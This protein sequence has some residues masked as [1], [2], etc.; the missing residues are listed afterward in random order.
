MK[1]IGYS[2]VIRHRKELMNILDDNMVKY[3]KLIVYKT[4]NNKSINIPMIFKERFQL[5]N[6]YNFSNKKRYYYWIFFSPNGVEILFNLLK[7]YNISKQNITKN[8]NIA[9][10][11]ET[12]QN[13]LKE[14]NVPCIFIP[15]KPTPNALFDAFI[16]TILS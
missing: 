1:Y 12:T 2:V 4:I 7:V 6:D 11:G 16:H 14:L 13:K 3:V 5:N 8:I 10:F 15:I 9:G